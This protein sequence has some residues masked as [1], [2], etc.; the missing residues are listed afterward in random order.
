VPVFKFSLYQPGDVVGGREIV[1]W[2]MFGGICRRGNVLHSR[3][4]RNRASR[5]PVRCRRHFGTSL[6]SP[7]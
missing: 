6:W 2:G 4:Y 5:T 7:D 1:R 3:Q